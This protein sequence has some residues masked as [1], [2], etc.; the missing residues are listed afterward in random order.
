MRLE[1]GPD[2]L[3]LPAPQCR[4]QRGDQ[5]QHPLGREPVIV[6][7]PGVLGAPEEGLD[8]GGVAFN[9][10]AQHLVDAREERRV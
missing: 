1:A 2:P 8:L 10:A 4:E 5:L 6:L 9:N 7:M 3:L